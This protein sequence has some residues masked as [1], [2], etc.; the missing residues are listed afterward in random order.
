V[1]EDETNADPDLCA[2][3]PIRIPG[4]IQPHGALLVLDPINLHMTQA[5][6]NLHAFTG[7]QFISGSSGWGSTEAGAVLRQELAEWL[8]HAD[9]NF[10]R[11]IQLG[12]RTVQASAHRSSQGVLVE[13]EEPPT[14]EADTLEA[15]YPR[16][17]A[18]VDAISGAEDVR[19]LAEAAVVE[20][21]AL[22]GF[23]RVMLYSFDTEG[24]GT[25]LA[26]DGDGELPSYLDLR[27]PASDI[28]VQARE[29]YRLNRLR[30]IPDANYRPIAI[31]PASSPMDGLPLDLSHAALRSVSPI[32]LQ[33]MRNMGTLSSMSISILVDG[34][35]WGLI[36]FH[37]AAPRQVNAQVRT[38]CDFLGQILSLQI[39]ARERSAQNIRRIALKDIE[40]GLVARMSQAAAFQDALLQNGPAWLKMVD[41]QG[42]A[43]VTPES[44]VT[45]GLTPSQPELEE[46]ALWL[47]QRGVTEVFFTDSLAAHWPQAESFAGPAS[48]L[49][50]ISIS[51]IH[52]SYILWFREE[53]VRT[54][55]WAGEP[56]KAAPLSPERLNPRQSFELWKQQVRMHSLPWETVEIESARD[57][58]NSIIAFVLRSAE[59]RAALSEQLLASNKELE[60]FTYSISHDLRAPFRH[61]TGYA[62]LLKDVLGD[63]HDKPAHYLRSIVEAATSAGQLVDDLLNFSQLGRSSLTPVR[64][65]VEKMV[66]E[67]RGSM[68][69]DLIGRDIEWDIG[70]LPTATADA[71]M[72]RQ[73]FTNLI[74]NAV[75]YSAGKEHTVITVRGHVADG[76]VHYAVTDNG[77]GFDMA[78]VGKL[79][80]VFRRLHR[81][82][83]FPGTGI[84]LALTKRIVER[85]GGSVNAQG[86]V[87]AGATFGFTLPLTPEESK[88]G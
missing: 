20:L 17:R 76:S 3:E 52:A 5:S 86:A 41:S 46:L 26:E 82:E 68:A 69:T 88:D 15:L 38:A 78:Y 27:F 81:T 55:K 79:F 43:L 34:H 84:G 12:P 42:A 59:E 87:G 47:S 49:L 33:Y 11:T 22:T 66:R 30:L 50:A 73:V 28:P 1:R 60:A 8:E 21:R 64:V 4:G 53:V 45:Y 57:F 51:Q 37:G 14:R 83:D 70:P 19:Q 25:V 24:T 29:L 75:K 9:K 65:D 61:I 13:F 56:T 62:A 44:L 31:E 80:G 2:Q 63:L 36:S 23:N 40:V 6:A 77:I 16:L 85:H 10:L 7:L 39:A 18:F 72:L 58:R 74:D 32:H 35:L 54:V 71:S 48:G 67:I